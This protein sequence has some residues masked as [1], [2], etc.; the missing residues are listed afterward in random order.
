MA[1]RH[2]HLRRKKLSYFRGPA[3]S[4]PI[5]IENP[6]T[7]YKTTEVHITSELASPGFPDT[8]RT[9]SYIELQ[10]KVLERQ[11]LGGR[12]E[13][14]EYSIT[15]ERNAN[16]PQR[17]I[18][19]MNEDEI[20]LRNAA[21]AAN[22]AAGS[23]TKCCVLMFISLL[24]T[25][26][27]SSI[28]RVYT[29]VHPAGSN[30]GIAYVAGLVLPLQGFWNA[31]IYVTISWDAVMDMFAGDIDQRVWRSWHGQWPRR[32]EWRDDEADNWGGR[33]RRLSLNSKEGRI[34]PGFV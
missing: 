32:G 11:Y 12:Q 6:F 20:K 25:W 2:L 30:F 19:A 28:F 21:L 16:A 5:V 33:P 15:I 14:E 7:S 34:G 31:V 26:I 4:A 23:Y 9:D 22:K 3:A 17:G 8:T 10:Q 27:P 29:L 24:V 1:G 18:E 13:F